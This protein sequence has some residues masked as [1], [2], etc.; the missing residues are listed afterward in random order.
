M[1]CYVMSYVH[2][3]DITYILL[4]LYFIIRFSA[5]FSSGRWN[6]SISCNSRLSSLSKKLPQYCLSARADNTTRSYKYAFDSWTKW[7]VSNNISYLPGSDYH[8]ALYLIDVTENDSSKSDSKINNIFYAISW[9]HRLAGLPDPCQTDL[10]NF[11]KEGALR[12]IGH[13]L[14]KKEPISPQI[15]KNIVLLYGND[16]SNL[17]DLRLACM[18]L[19][20][21]AGFLRFSELANLKRSNITFQDQFVQLYLE[22]SKTD[23]YR[24]GKDVLISRT[25]NI[26]CP[27]TMLNRYLTA[28]GIPPDSS[29][30]IF[31]GLT[32]FKND[33]SYRLR[34]SGKL[35]Y[36]TA[37]DILL[38][39][40]HDMG[41][42]KK[43]FGLHSLRS[44]GCTA[45]ASA[46]VEDRIFKKHGRWKSDRAKDGYVKE[47]LS[48]RLSVTKKI[49]I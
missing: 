3:L 40:L 34:N 44:G 2:R 27:V 45:A 8:V 6:N 49:G 17:K 20:A 13:S 46:N 47:N 36:S 31:R 1:V 5:I 28:A 39:A 33:N 10:V 29:D 15:L 24:E 35:S 38:S 30:Y 19:L 22:Q 18:C 43:K 41:L 48:E 26:T 42:D 32:Y 12:K 4:W 21:F 25:D 11:V 7:C 37:R 23:I 16:K 9:A 14:N